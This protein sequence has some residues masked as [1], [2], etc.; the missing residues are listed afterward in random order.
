MA[1]V[2]VAVAVAV[3][4]VVDTSSDR[5]LVGIGYR[6]PL[7]P[8]IE[9]HP[10]ELE[11]LEITAEHFFGGGT[12]RLRELARRYPLFVH[13]LGL[14]LGT[15]GPLDNETLQRFAAVVEVA[16][17]EW[18]SEHIAFT[19]SH[20]VDLG[21]LNPV[22]PSR[23][24]LDIVADH[25]QELAELC[26]KP[27]ILEN[28]TSHL[29]LDGEMSEPDFLNQLCEQANCGLLL[30]VTN[31]FINSKNHAFDPVDW[32]DQLDPSHIV[33]LH[34]VGYSVRNG[35]W[36]DLHTE[37]IQEDL[38]ELIYKVL[39]RA[40]ARAITLERDGNFPDPADLASE[41]AL[42]KDALE[43]YGFHD[44]AGAAAD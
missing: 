36:H 41:L 11:C 5:S 25:A 1:G 42:L 4:G 3:G 16:D 40:P 7:A 10:P 33:Q 24:A 44:G 30:D 34:V 17:P 27:L 35:R 22:R 38:R 9:R 26:R 6:F 29:R 37:P 12:D 28:V 2:A 8:W 21:H 13:G 19:R 20:E 15:P 18:V 31:L 43:G 23:D 14:S 39:A 32:L